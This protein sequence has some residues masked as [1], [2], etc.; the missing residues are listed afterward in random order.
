MVVSF[1]F[2]ELTQ[3]KNKQKHHIPINKLIIKTSV[4]MGTLISTTNQI[5]CRPLSTFKRGQEVIK[6]VIMVRG[7]MK[8]LVD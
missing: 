6:V 2:G 7:V 3:N 5:R 8:D 4:A 1:W